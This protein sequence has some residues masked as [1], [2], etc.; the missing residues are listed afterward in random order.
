MEGLFGVRPDALA[1]VLDLA[2]G[3]PA[4]WDRA[5]LRHP[6]VGLEFARSGD[7]DRYRVE[8]RFGAPQALRLTLPVRRDRVASVTVDGRAVRFRVVEDQPSG[9]HLAVEA[10]PAA[11]HEVA[12]TWAGR[13]VAAAVPEPAPVAPAPAAFDWSAARPTGSAWEPI[14]LGAS[15]NDRLT[16]I[17]ENEYRSPRSPFVSLAM[18]KQGLGG[19]AGT[20]N[21][22]AAIDDSGLRGLPGGRL[23]LPNGVPFAPAAVGPN[24]V[25]TSQWDNYP[26]EAVVPLAGR[27]RRLYLLMAG[28]T[29]AMQSRID[30]GEVEVAYADGSRERLALENPTTWWPIEQDYFLDDFAFALP[31]PLPPRVDLRTGSVRLLDPQAFKGRGGRVPGGAATVLQL[32][33]D[34]AKPLASLTVRALA[35]EVVIGLLAATLER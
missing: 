25:F 6:R 16:R 11:A 7:V 29:N 24:V 8:T 12:I 14:D 28:S 34:P 31:G 15:F 18:P 19:W 35:N 2:P 32:P 30:N 22:T 13:A 1:G 26:R 5:R 9:R 27:A 33:L 4:E 10:P 23:V 21:A 20:V 3:F 17:F